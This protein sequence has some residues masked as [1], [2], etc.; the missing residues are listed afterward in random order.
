MVVD[1]SEGEGIWPVGGMEGERAGVGWHE[2]LQ[3]V[4]TMTGR[5]MAW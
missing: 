5:K 2:V 1:C 4:G 3:R